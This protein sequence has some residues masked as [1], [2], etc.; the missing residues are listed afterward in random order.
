LTLRYI[1][2]S[3]WVNNEGHENILL[4]GEKMAGV[5]NVYADRPR[6]VEGEHMRF[7]GCEG[8]ND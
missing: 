2:T 3:T 7:K 4:R 1:P 5:Q 6:F 8:W